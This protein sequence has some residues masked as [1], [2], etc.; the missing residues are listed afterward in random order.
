[1]NTSA[2][3]Q[4]QLSTPQGGSLLATRGG[5]I[6]EQMLASINKIKSFRETGEI[7]VQS[8]MG[9]D[10]ITGLSDV[11]VEN[12]TEY[13][14]TMRCSDQVLIAEPNIDMHSRQPSEFDRGSY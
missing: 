14:T 8:Q 9:Q 13:H 3:S 2:A 6:R 1:M 5:K 7:D 11:G 4:E 10:R 12:P